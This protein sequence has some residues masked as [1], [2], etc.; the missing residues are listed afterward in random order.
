MPS[1]QARMEYVKSI[2]KRYL[3]AAKEEKSRILEE[4]CK[5]CRYN[6]KYAIRLLNGPP[7][8]KTVIRRK[9]PFQYSQ[10]VIKI[11]EAIW[12]ASSFLCGQR[13]KEAIPLW[14]PF[15]KK[16]FHISTD[17][18]HQL[19]CISARQLDNRLRPYK[20]YWKKRIYSTTRPGSLLKHMIPVRTNHWDIRNPGYMEIDLVAHCGSSLSG[21]FLYT[22]NTTD[23]RTGWTER[24][25][26]MGKGQ[27][28]VF[29][30]LMAIRA[31][32]PF[33]LRGIDCDNGEEFINYHLLSFCMQSR[34][35]IAFTRSRPYKRDDN[36]HVEQK[37]WTH[38]RQI[39]GWDRYDTQEAQ[40]AMNDL[41]ANEL[42]LFQNLFQPS[43]KLKRRI[44]IGSRTVRRYDRPKTPLQRVFESK[45]CDAEKV[46]KLKHLQ[47]TLDPFELSEQIDEKLQHIFEL[48][49]QRIPRQHLT[50]SKPFLPMD[51]ARPLPAPHMRD[52]CYT[53]KNIKLQTTMASI[54]RQATFNHCKSQKKEVASVTS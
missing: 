54:V 1:Y 9:R 3:R 25:A 12:K 34:P 48:A 44:R 6:R 27:A 39:F 53:K 49:T 31:D 2:Q 52:Y 43:T 47:A 17:M 19:L 36:A 11:A 5:T 23:I 20:R 21:S 8:E 13:L 35:R 18:E 7:P 24:R 37:N 46:E 51:P 26:V 22:L 33:T 28:A 10:Q 4:F 30:A 15:A 50:E 42:R 41:Y 45:I 16:R 32:I 29:D 38:V 14:L 40:S